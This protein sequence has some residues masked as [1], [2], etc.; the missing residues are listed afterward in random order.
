MDVS[1]ATRGV[2]LGLV[3]VGGVSG[4][5]LVRLEDIDGG[6]R[7]GGVGEGGGEGVR[8]GGGRGIVR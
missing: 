5:V 8:G 3:K 7:S 6:I 4:G 1:A 2:F